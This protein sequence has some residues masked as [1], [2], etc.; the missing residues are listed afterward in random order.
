METAFFLFLI[1]TN[2]PGRELSSFVAQQ[3]M[4]S[5]GQ[6]SG[7]PLEIPQASSIAQQGPQATTGTPQPLRAAAPPHRPRTSTL[8]L[9]DPKEL[10][11]EGCKQ[12]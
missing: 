8:G 3:S 12:Q 11:E 7:S 5:Q 10:E 6:F 4:I 9:Q 2:Q 1:P